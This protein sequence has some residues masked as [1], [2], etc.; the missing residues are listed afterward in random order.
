MKD[1][2]KIIETAMN[3]VN[4]AKPIKGVYY[5]FADK[6]IIPTYQSDPLVHR[7]NLDVMETFIDIRGDYIDLFPAFGASMNYMRGKFAEHMHQG[8]AMHILPRVGL[9]EEQRLSDIT[10]A[11]G[12]VGVSLG[13]KDTPEFITKVISDENVKFLSIDVAHGAS[14][15]VLPLL[16]LLTELGVRN[17]VMV[18]NVGSVQGLTFLTSI[19]HSLEYE[20][21]IVKVGVGPGSVCTTRVNTGV[22]VGQL[23]LLENIYDHVTMAPYSDSVKIISDGGV[24]VAGDFVKALSR[25]HGV[26]MGKFF[27]SHSFENKVLNFDEEGNAFA[28]LYGMASQRIANKSSFIEGG[29]QRVYF[30]HNSA[31]EALDSLREGLQSAMSYV[32]AKDL[33]EFRNNVEFAINS[34]GAIIEGGVH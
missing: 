22:G 7:A 8:H 29:E 31:H 28:T 30:N 9:S 32:N 4:Y 21:Y 18:G 20:N 11:N 33:T 12:P 1:Y 16:D 15:H 26:M 2:P 27:T 6:N 25:S 23:T 17:G 34:Y 24:N 19:M 5:T 10:M 14:A 13:I 3:E